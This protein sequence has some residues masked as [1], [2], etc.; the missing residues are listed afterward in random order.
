MTIADMVYKQVKL[1]PDPLP[2]KCLISS[3]SFVR[4]AIAQSGAI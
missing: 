4:G 1:L 3:A 2:A